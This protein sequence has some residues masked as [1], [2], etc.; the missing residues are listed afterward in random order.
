LNDVG[1]SGSAY[2]SYGLKCWC[3]R[4]M[5]EMI[6]EELSSFFTVLI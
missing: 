1:E 3:Y 4:I 2:V 6:P 5:W